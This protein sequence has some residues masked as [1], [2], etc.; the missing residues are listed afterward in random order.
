LSELI[1]RTVKRREDV[2]EDGFV[3]PNPRIANGNGE[4]PRIDRRNYLDLRP[5]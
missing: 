2:F 3:D 1:I 5:V 4:P